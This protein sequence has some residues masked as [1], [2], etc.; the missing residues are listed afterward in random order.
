M[1]YYTVVS[2]SPF[3]AYPFV[4]IPLNDPVVSYI[5]RD[6]L[7]QLQMLLPRLRR[8]Y[9]SGRCK[10]YRCDFSG[11]RYS[12]SGV[13]VVVLVVVVLLLLVVVV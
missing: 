7:T 13:V 12:G 4:M 10:R 1:H 8:Y 3:S 5:A 9:S 6:T 2:Y 11:R